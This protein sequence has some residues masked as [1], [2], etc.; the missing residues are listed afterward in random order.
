MQ[1]QA[2]RVNILVSLAHTN[3]CTYV[4][5]WDKLNIKTFIIMS[6]RQF[7]YFCKTTD[8]MTSVASSL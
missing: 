7:I 4:Y 6:T 3:I 2:D 8:F 1:N 5:L